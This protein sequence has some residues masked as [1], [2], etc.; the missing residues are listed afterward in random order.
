LGQIWTK[1][2]IGLN[3]Y[4]YLFNPTFGFV[5]IWPKVACLSKLHPNNPAC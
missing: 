4:Y 2:D 5:H 1:T 3:F